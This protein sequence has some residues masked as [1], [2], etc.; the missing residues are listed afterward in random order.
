MNTDTPSAEFDNWIAEKIGLCQTTQPNLLGIS[1]HSRMGDD[2]FCP[3]ERWDHAMRAAELTK[4][5]YPCHGRNEEHALDAGCFRQLFLMVNGHGWYLVV[6]RFWSAM[7][8]S[9]FYF[10]KG[11]M[12]DIYSTISSHESGPMAICQAIYNM[13]CGT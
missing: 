4:L 7:R 6:A 12:S 11:T 2:D 1:R 5:F 3:T 8:P 13:N 10:S 9:D